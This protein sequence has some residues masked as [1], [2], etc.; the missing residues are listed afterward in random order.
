LS[1]PKYRCP[2]CGNTDR[3]D[4]SVICW[5]RLDQR[6]P[7]NL[8]TDIDTSDQEWDGDSSIHCNACNHPGKVH[9]FAVVAGR[10]G[11]KPVSKS[12]VTVGDLRAAIK[13]RPDAEPVDL[14]VEFDAAGEDMSQSCPRLELDGV[15][16]ADNGAPTQLVIIMSYFD[17]DEQEDTPEGG[18]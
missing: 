6:N 16:H 18:G 14:K 7:D 12:R 4:I 1:E 2:R 11:D 13:G 15:E 8:E 9:Q 5:A 17:A 10:N 3:L